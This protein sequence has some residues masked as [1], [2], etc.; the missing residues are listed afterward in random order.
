MKL[1][2][3]ATTSDY[4]VNGGE[5]VVLLDA[6]PFLYKACSEASLYDAQAVVELVY[7]R[8]VEQA[9][10]IAAAVRRST[11]SS[12]LLVVGIDQRVRDEINSKLGVQRARDAQL[13]AH[14]H[15]VRALMIKRMSAT[16]VAAVKD[17]LEKATRFAGHDLFAFCA[18]VIATTIVTSLGEQLV[19]MRV[20]AS[21]MLLSTGVPNAENAIPF[22]DLPDAALP[23]QPPT[24]P[25][26]VQSIVLEKALCRL[27]VMCLRCCDVSHV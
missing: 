2:P 15:A 20:R 12:V 5:L 26:A 3:D 7:R 14:Y 16:A 21:L 18:A 10:A 9:R 24:T 11:A 17:S 13:K 6:A 25:G 19:C 4:S 22:V 1:L 23:Q 27:K 8:A